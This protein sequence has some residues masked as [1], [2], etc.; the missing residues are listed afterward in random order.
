MNDKAQQALQQYR[1]KVANGEI[2]KENKTPKQKW[3]G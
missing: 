2:V 3:E 1:N